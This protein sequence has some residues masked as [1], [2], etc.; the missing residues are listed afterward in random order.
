MALS[1]PPSLPFSTNVGTRVVCEAQVVEALGL[2]DLVPRLDL[3]LFVWSSSFG[4][5]GLG[6]GVEGLGP[7]NHGSCF[8]VQASGFRV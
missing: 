3:P 2:A 5:Q 4:V 6:F 8:R 1:L 7:R